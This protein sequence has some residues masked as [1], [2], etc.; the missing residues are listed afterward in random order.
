MEKQSRCIGQP[1]RHAAD[2]IL[3]LQNDVCRYHVSPYE[4]E[5][6]DCN[7]D[8]KIENLRLLILMFIIAKL[9]STLSKKSPKFDIL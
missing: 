2:I 6:I 9:Q 1:I 3:I 4:S 5:H 7:K 8:T